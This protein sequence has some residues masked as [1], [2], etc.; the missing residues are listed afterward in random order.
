MAEIFV[1]GNKGE[2]LQAFAERAGNSLGLS[3][4]EARESSNYAGGE[5]FRS[6]ALAMSIVFARSDGSEGKDLQFWIVLSLDA[7][8][9]DEESFVESMADLVA[10]KLTIAGEEVIRVENAWSQERA[11]RISYFRKM[12]DDGPSKHEVTTS[13]G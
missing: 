11:R 10:R 13:E 2:S 3:A 12:D 9:V 4:I 7:I 5:Y 1:K 8:W 6:S